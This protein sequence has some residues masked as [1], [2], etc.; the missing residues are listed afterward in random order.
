MVN[1]IRTGISVNSGLMRETSSVLTG[2][3][4][5]SVTPEKRIPINK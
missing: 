3:T 4:R 1:K 5:A 2:E